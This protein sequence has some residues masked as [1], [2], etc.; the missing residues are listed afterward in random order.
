MFVHILGFPC[1]SDGKES[2]HNAGDLG[3]IPG[4]G[5]SP[6]RGYGYPL[7][8]F[9]PGEFHAQKS[10]AGYSPWGHK[11][12]DTTEQL[13]HTHMYVLLLLLSHSIVSDSLPPHGLQHARLPWPSLSPRVCS[14]YRCILLVD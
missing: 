10:L 8:V 11:E 2:A 4:S 3:L 7:L 6:G 14:N 9:W 5:R 12:A 13:T 1:G